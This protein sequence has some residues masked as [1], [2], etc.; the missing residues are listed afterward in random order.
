[1]QTC[2]TC[3]SKAAHGVGEKGKESERTGGNVSANFGNLLPRQLHRWI[4]DDVPE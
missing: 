2:R 1:M 3:G 4:V